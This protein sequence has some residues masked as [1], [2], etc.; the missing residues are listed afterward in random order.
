MSEQYSLLVEYDNAFEA[1]LAKGLLEENGI[2]ARLNN[3]MI[4]S[5]YT[6]FAGDMFRL[7]LWVPTEQVDLAK[8]ILET[9]T[10]GFFTSRLLKQVDALLEGH[11]LLTSGRHSA[12]YIEKI[13]IL[14]SPEQTTELC[15]Q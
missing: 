1:D 6:T 2:P 15:R 11:F 7:E 5:I 8:D 14:Q 9:Y 3:E 10:D 13:K 12:R 4:N